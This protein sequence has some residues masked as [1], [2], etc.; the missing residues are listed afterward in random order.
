MGNNAR[1]AYLTLPHI[2][3]SKLTDEKERGC[4]KLAG[5]YTLTL[6]ASHRF[7]HIWSKNLSDHLGLSTHT[8]SLH[9]QLP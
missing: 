8:Q 5:G 3:Y 9:F 7:I 6:L 2:E 4:F 1:Y